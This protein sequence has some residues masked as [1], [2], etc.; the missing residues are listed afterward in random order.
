MVMTAAGA[1]LIWAVN[2]TSTDVNL[3]A[4][5]WV[6]FILGLFGIALSIIFWS[7]W[8]ISGRRR[9]VIDDRG[10]VTEE[11]TQTY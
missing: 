11:R 1:V 5:G 4:V 2:V 9:T 6:L 7:T 3:H 10:R 8:G